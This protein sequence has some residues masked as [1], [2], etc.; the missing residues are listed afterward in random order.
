M[1]FVI[2]VEKGQTLQDIAREYNTTVQRLRSLNGI[3]ENREGERLLV[4]KIEGTPYRVQ[5]FETLDSIAEKFGVSRK[6][7]EKI[8]N[9]TE[10]FF[11]EIIYIPKAL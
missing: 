1:I 9:V 6:Q 2:R 11:G 5:P 10:V 4:E 3:M 8:N 7:I